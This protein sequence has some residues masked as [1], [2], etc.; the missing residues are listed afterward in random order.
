MKNKLLALLTGMSLA[1]CEA[2]PPAEPGVETAPLNVPAVA[3][4]TVTL[5]DGASDPAILIDG[6]DPS[7]SRILG[8]GLAGGLELYDLDGTRIGIMPD[9]P[10]GLVDVV[11]RPGFAVADVK[12]HGWLRFS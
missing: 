9:R 8:A 6:T 3:E 5:T 4:T 11:D 1:A 12:W 10:I 2:Q 7:Q